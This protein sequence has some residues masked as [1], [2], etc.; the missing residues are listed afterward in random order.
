MPELIKILNTG[1]LNIGYTVCSSVN[2]DLLLQAPRCL[3]GYRYLYNLSEKVCFFS[4]HVLYAPQ[5]P[6]LYFW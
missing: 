6:N 2:A 5:L 4:L 3:A 1:M